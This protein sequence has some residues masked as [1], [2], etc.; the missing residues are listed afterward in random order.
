MLNKNVNNI[1]NLNITE[2]KITKR[3]VFHIPKKTIAQSCYVN[4]KQIAISSAKYFLNSANIKKNVSKHTFTSCSRSMSLFSR[5]KFK[6][7]PWHE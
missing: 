4:I 3:D 6:A 2:Y 7:A 5:T 1:N